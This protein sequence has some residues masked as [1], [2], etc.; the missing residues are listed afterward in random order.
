MFITIDLYYSLKLG[1]V[2]PQAV[3]IVHDSFSYF[4]ISLFV[5][6]YEAEIVIL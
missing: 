2:R 6:A 1:M 3:L 5:F 4:A